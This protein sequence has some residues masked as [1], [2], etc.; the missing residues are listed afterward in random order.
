MDHVEAVYEVKE[1]HAFKRTLQNHWRMD[2]TQP[3][4][5]CSL[6]DDCADPGGVVMKV[7]DISYRE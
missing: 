5:V 1:G 2:S 3:S 6:I 7:M 4:C